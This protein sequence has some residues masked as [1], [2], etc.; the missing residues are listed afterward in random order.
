M[1]TLNELIAQLNAST[2]NIL[3]DAGRLNTTANNMNQ[4]L[5][6]MGVQ[7]IS[8]IEGLAPDKQDLYKEE[9]YSEQVPT[10]FSNNITTDTTAL[11]PNTTNQN[12]NLTKFGYQQNKDGIMS[13]IKDAVGNYFQRGGAL[14]MATDFLGKF[15]PDMDPRQSALRNYY[16][17]D[18]I[19]R[20]P[21]GQLMAGYNPVSGGLLHMLTGGSF[22]QPTNYG[23]QDAYQKR[24]DMINRT[25]ARKYADGDYSNTQ[26]DERLKQLQSDKIQESMMLD[27]VNQNTAFE[28]YQNDPGSYSGGE[29][30]TN[31]GGQN[32]TSY[33]DPFD[34][35]G[36]E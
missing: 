3:S 7:E 19:G 6:G 13:Q 29:T 16:G 10:T 22:G 25:L 35:G 2:N 21:Q 33:S 11:V 5:N 20:V 9:M 15:I 30:T 18:S 1:A 8:G 14:G 34:P 4:T 28:N 31:V 12:K 24:I 32:I 36:G 17:Y 26:L 23:L 27:Q